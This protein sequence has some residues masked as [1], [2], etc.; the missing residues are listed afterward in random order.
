VTEKTG[1]EQLPIQQP[2]LVL[3]GTEG[4]PGSVPGLAN[5]ATCWPKRMQRLRDQLGNYIHLK[6]DETGEQREK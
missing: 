6:T 3:A 2:Q 5:T 4:G 1:S